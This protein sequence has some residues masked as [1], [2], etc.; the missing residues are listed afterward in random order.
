MI[1][2][3]LVIGFWIIFVNALVFTCLLMTKKS[4][5]NFVN[6]QMLSLSLTDLFVGLSTVPLAVTYKLTA[7][8]PYFESCVG[9]YYV[10]CVSQAANLFHAF[11]ICLHRL[12]MIKGCAGRSERNPKHKLQTILFQIA[13]IWATSVL[14]VSLPFGFYSRFGTRLHEC[15]LNSLYG[16]NYITV[17]GIINSIYLIP[18]IGMNVVYIYL[19]KYL[20]TT[21]R[22]INIYRK[23]QMQPVKNEHEDNITASNTRSF[24]QN[25]INKRVAE[26]DMDGHNNASLENKNN[27]SNAQKTST[28]ET[29]VGGVNT[30][31]SI[32]GCTFSWK[33]F[34]CAEYEITNSELATYDH[35]RCC[36]AD[37]FPDNENPFAT[38]LQCFPHDKEA[39]QNKGP[40]RHSTQSYNHGNYSDECVMPRKK[41][42]SFSAL[43]R[44]FSNHKCCSN[45]KYKGQKRVLI[46][47]GMILLAVNIFM[48][49]LN[50]LIV[51][52]LINKDLLS[53]ETK[54]IPFSLSLMNSA[55]NP[56]IYT[57]RIKPFRAAF[58]RNWNKCIAQV[59]SHK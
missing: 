17:L 24:I 18:Q 48:T 38:E 7:P 22:N 44:K 35:S 9:I 49:P 40:R 41:R 42:K 47:I 25:D 21:W 3:S 36:A 27:D 30:N 45:L 37:D 4:V 55:V 26:I 28:P 53:R 43:R 15:S 57:L 54:L 56:I 33:S 20:L 29:S 31:T 8:F 12:I 46:T 13:I 52:E 1:V 11:G 16:E 34:I 59:C 10:Y 51:F 58:T 6:I 5:K 50:L 32:K 14:L 23:P 19:F 39:T 2:I